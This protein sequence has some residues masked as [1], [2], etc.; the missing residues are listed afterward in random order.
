MECGEKLSPKEFRERV[1]EEEAREAERVAAETPGLVDLRNLSPRSRQVIEAVLHITRR[2]LGAAGVERS[3][4]IRRVGAALQSYG[5]NLVPPAPQTAALPTVLQM[6]TFDPNTQQSF[7]PGYHGQDFTSS[8]VQS[9]PYSMVMI[10]PAGFAPFPSSVHPG[11]MHQFQGQPVAP[12][13][14]VAPTT[15][16]QGHPWEWWPGNPDTVWNPQV[17]LINN[18]DLK[19]RI[20]EINEHSWKDNRLES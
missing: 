5:A 11:T 20:I 6:S 15:Q 7:P 17:Y 9:A 14:S 3:Q 19:T 18:R 4:V 10:P 1:K 8:P 16:I 2:E 13:T 12:P